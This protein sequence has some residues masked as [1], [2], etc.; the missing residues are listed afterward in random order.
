M[1]W[2]QWLTLLLLPLLS[3]LAHADLQPIPA[4]TGLVVDPGGVLTY[5]QTHALNSKLEQFRRRN[6]SEIGVLIVPTSHPEDIF[7]YAFRVASNWKLGQNGADNGVLI[8]IATDDHAD[9]IQVG[10]GL[11]GALPDARCKDI[12]QDVMAPHFHDLDYAGGLE[13]GTDAIMSAIRGE[14]FW[15]GKIRQHGGWLSWLGGAFMGLAVAGL[16]ALFANRTLGGVLG[17][18]IGGGAALGLGAGSSVALMIGVLILFL[19]LASMAR[20]VGVGVYGNG[21]G[22]SYGY[23]SRRNGYDDW[24]SN[25]YGGSSS[26][27]NNSSSSDGNFGGGGASGDW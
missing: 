23:Q 25:S 15:T 4:R 21:Y 24:G 1:R 16:V 8:V 9:N 11:E 18:L 27:S 22:V 10:Y 26:G 7:S 6:G 3:L 14:H 13:A 20:S 2:H 12:L 17:G 19:M 5:S